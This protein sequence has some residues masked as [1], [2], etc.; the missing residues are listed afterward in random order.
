MLQSAPGLIFTLFAG[1][2]TDKFGRKPLIICALVGYLLLD[3][4]FIINTYWFLELKVSS[5]VSS[6]VET[7][8]G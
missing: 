5:S 7:K 6:C 3:I 4:I 8:L 2:M 1:P